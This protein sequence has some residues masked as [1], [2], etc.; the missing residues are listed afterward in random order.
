MLIL[1]VNVLAVNVLA[2]HVSLPP[3]SSG[4]VCSVKSE[5]YSLDSVK[6]DILH[7]T[8]CLL[9]ALRTFLGGGR[10]RRRRV[11][12]GPDE[13]GAVQQLGLSGGLRGAACEP[14]S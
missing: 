2:V 8:Y 12:V 9:L 1:P 6:N 11:P 7:S 14:Q 5:I 4:P 3:P 13:A 10:A